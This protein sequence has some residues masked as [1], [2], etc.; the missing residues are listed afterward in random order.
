MQVPCIVPSDDLPERKVLGLGIACLG[1]FLYLFMFCSVE[2]VK[3]VQ[4]NM[5]VDWDVKT[6][7]AADYTCEFSITEEMYEYFVDKYLDTTNPLSEI[8]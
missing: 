2:Y 5:F 4:D 8:G 1:V 6:I 7:S 3:S